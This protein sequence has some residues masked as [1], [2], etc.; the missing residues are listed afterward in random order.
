MCNVEITKDCVEDIKILGKRCRQWVL[1]IVDYLKDEE[2]TIEMIEQHFPIF[3]EA[4]M[5]IVKRRI[6]VLSANSIHN[7]VR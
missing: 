5:V 2:N 3:W 6:D 1:A 4:C 7:T